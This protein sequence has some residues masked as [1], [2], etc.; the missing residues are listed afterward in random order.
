GQDEIDA[1]QE[2]LQHTCRF[3][4]ARYVILATN[5]AET[6]ITIDGVSFVIDPGVV[7]Q[8]ISFN[9]FIV[10]KSFCSSKIWKS[11]LGHCFQLYTQHAFHNE[12]EENTV[13]EVQR[14]NLANVV[15]MLK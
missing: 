11:W 10:F 7:K 2:S 9:H 3:L 14:T 12:L 4:E 8:N 13:P 15:L 5:I 1:V 6:S